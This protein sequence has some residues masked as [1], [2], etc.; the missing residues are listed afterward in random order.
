[1][2]SCRQNKLSLCP[3]API[4]WA[5]FLKIIFALILISIV[6]S[7]T[8]FQEI[9]ALKGSISWHWLL[10]SFLLYC[11]MTMLKGVQYWALLGGEITYIQIL[12]IVVIQNTLANLVANA[13][14][15]ISYLTLFRVEYN[16]KLGR[17]GATFLI[18]KMGDLLSI[19][20]F[21]L[22]SAFLVWDRIEELHNLVIGLLIGIAILLIFFWTIAFLRRRFIS[23]IE[24][25]F[26]KLHLQKIGFL[27]RGFDL[28]KSLANQDHSIVWKMLLRGV[29]VSIIYMIFSML[30]SFCRVQIF[31]IPID[32]WAIVFIASL[33]QLVSAI[34]FQVFGGLGVTE[35]SLLYLYTLFQV[36]GVDISAILVGLR[37]VF[38]LF[39]IVI[40][41]YVPVDI[42]TERLKQ[43]KIEDNN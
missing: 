38:Y 29:F 36:V 27:Q 21:L 31:D 19:G 37:I 40:F 33:M 1:M 39:N 9:T 28:F 11:F 22:A 30:Y 43:S 41:L 7:R 4:R 25:L 3:S 16:I 10:A 6:L 26:F 13:A 24:I 5:D 2:K 14:G 20:F 18:T 15:L 35:M 17:L 34:P 32:F 12:K 8:S 42:I 23:Q